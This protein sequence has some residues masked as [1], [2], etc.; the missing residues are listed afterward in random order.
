LLS[1]L[2]L[3]EIFCTKGK[4][5]AL[6]DAVHT[7]PIERRKYKCSRG[8]KEKAM[9][10]IRRALSIQGAKVSTIDGLRYDFPGGWL[11]VR[12]SG[13]EPAMRLTCECMDKAKL[14]EIVAVAEKAILAAVG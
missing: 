6:A 2:V 12:P 4:L 10:N 3:A 13:T 11:L 7:Y 9:E 1:A 5:S 14:G 8:G